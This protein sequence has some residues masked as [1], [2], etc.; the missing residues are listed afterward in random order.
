MKDDKSKFI[1]S[2]VYSSTDKYMILKDVYRII[3]FSFHL[4]ELFLHLQQVY[5]YQ[6]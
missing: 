6:S 3:I 1:A 5:T 4:Y 2:K